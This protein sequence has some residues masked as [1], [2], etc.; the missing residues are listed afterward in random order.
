[1]GQVSKS[2]ITEEEWQTR[3]DLATAYNL[4]S[5]FQWTDLIYTHISARIPGQENRFLINPFGLHFHEVTPENLVKI[6][7]EGEFLSKSDYGINPAGLVIH[8]AIHSARPDVGAIV[9]LHTI[10][11]MAVSALQDGLL[12]ISQAACHFYG[13]IAYHDYEG[14]AVHK[15]EKQRL[16]KD[17]GSKNVM[18]LR[19]HGF[20]TA[21]SNVA[22]AFTKMYT[23]EKAAQVQITSLS[24]G[25]PIVIPSE[26]ICEKVVEDTGKRGIKNAE[27]EW[28]ALKRLIP[29]KQESIALQA[30]LK[31]ASLTH[32][33]KKPSL[34]QSQKVDQNQ[35]RTAN[36]RPL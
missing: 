12:P 9:H 7:L 5:L 15:D 4:A 36:D 25:L 35:R 34:M 11:G 30:K 2:Y 13:K 18:I 20:L 23:L 16:I 24:M 31:P 22:E 28:Q 6:N 19:N 3:C 21:G 1:M 33:T 14:I 32:L 26:A 8:S 17:L 27:I 29:S 10:N